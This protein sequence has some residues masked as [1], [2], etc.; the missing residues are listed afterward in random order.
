M[1]KAKQPMNRTFL[2]VPLRPVLAAVLAGV[3]AG[4]ASA[5]QPQM[6]RAAQPAD[7]Q[8]DATA[9]TGIRREVLQELGGDAPQPVIR[10]GSGAPINQ[11]VAAPR[12]HRW[13]AAARPAS[14]SR[15]NRCMRWSRR[16]SATCWART[17]C[18]APGVQGT[19]TAGH[20]QAGQRRPARSSLLDRCWAGTTRAWSTATVATTSSRPTRRWPAAWRRAPVRLRC[21]RG[22]ESRVVPLRYVSAAEMEKILKPYARPNAI[23]SVDGARNLITVAGTRA[24]LE[25]YLRTIEIFDV[26]WMAGMSVGV[27]PLQS[28]RATRRGRR[29]WRRCS[30]SRASRRSPACSAS[31]RWKAPTR[32]W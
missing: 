14:T 6:H 5:P 30:A 9:G 12:R 25:N 24:E 17:T 21:A 27:F 32:C 7:Q 20:A 1:T 2:R 31:C 10:R 28:G 19:V 22:F 11:A 8:V 4:C 29:T 16:S 23:V 15:A 26:D 13:P 18:I 3:L